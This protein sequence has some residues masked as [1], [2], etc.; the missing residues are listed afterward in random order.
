MSSIDIA[1]RAFWVDEHPLNL[2]Y[3]RQH[4]GQSFTLS[5]FV[6][7]CTSVPQPLQHR[8]NRVMLNHVVTKPAPL[9]FA[10]V[11]DIP[12]GQ[13]FA[14][15]LLRSRMGNDLA[16][17]IVAHLEEMSLPRPEKSDWRT[18][19]EIGYL[20]RRP[21]QDDP[22]QTYLAMTPRGL[23][24]QARIAADWAVKFRLHHVTYTRTKGVGTHA[25]CCCGR[26]SQSAGNSD[27]A[28]HMLMRKGA[29]H[30][31]RMRAD[32]DYDET[33]ATDR[34]FARLALAFETPRRPGAAVELPRSATAA[35]GSHGDDR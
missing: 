33:A 13:K 25:S 4:P 35:P 15:L 8:S 18:L 14:L 29:E 27:A 12:D 26:W 24:A 21:R 32:P 20:T 7:W 9:S 3:R 5:E 31:D 10:P 2:A 17:L 6:R 23:A 30:V 11:P 34:A 28:E 1:R 19:I 22:T 16:K